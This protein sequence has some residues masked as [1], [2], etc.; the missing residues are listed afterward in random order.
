MLRPESKT[1]GFS[2]PPNSS[3]PC[4]STTI[5]SSFN[6]N[7]FVSLKVIIIGG[8]LGGLSASIA[9]RLAGHS[10]TVLEKSS[11]SSEVGAAVTL[12]PHVVRILRSWGIDLEQYGATRRYGVDTVKAETLEILSTLE[13]DDVKV[14]GEVY[15]AMHRVD[16][17]SAL[18]DK[19]LGE[20]EP[21]RPVTLQL[22]S[23]V[24]S[25]EAD[26]GIV[27][28][29]NGPDLRA[30]LIVAA[31]GVHSKA[32]SYIM[33][34]PCP[35]HGS[36]YKVIR[37]LI[38]S[39]EILRD[40]I[41]APLMA[42]EK[43]FL[44]FVAVKGRR[45]YMV[46]YPCR[47]D[48]LQNFALYI[49]DPPGP[50]ER[51]NHVG[52]GAQCGRETLGEAMQGFHPAFQKLVEKTDEILPVWRC[53]EREPLPVCTRGTL[54]MIGDAAHPMLPHRG[55]GFSSALQD[56]AALGVV[57][58]NV[59]SSEPEDVTKR[60]ERYQDFRVSR[61]A[62]V[63]LYSRYQLNHLDDTEAKKHGLQWMPE[64]KLPRSMR[65]SLSWF[66]H[67]DIVKELR[68]ELGKNY[69]STQPRA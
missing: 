22:G 29:S 42:H 57:F 14:Y 5:M 46:R 27:H 30:D 37:F 26:T 4:M 16:V 44:L 54:V 39:E 33:G 1:N 24:E 51:Y 58:E 60:L 68:E 66:Q 31:D 11:F 25:Y 32:A 10:V 34:R 36:D 67:Y 45:G 63:T 65:E 48:S 21:G 9:L 40:P 18:K 13:Q 35:V 23:A 3:S 8:G 15:Y 6:P 49:D 52:S 7:P 53:A 64:E 62:V 69:H 19:A 28:L 20:Q 59:K 43:G 2:L 61:N 55:Q 17:H 56:A 38:P 12:G 41:T 47:N 50:G